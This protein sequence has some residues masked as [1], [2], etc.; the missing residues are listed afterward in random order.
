[1]NT[2]KIRRW[3][4]KTFAIVAM[5]VLILGGLMLTGCPLGEYDIGFEDGFAEDDW[6][7]EGYDDSWEAVEYEILYEGDEIPSPTAPEYDRG[8]WDG[9]WTAYNDGYFVAYDDAFSIGFE[10]GYTAAFFEDYEDF[11][12]SDVHV[13]YG[14]GNYDDGYNDGFSE[15]RVFG[16]YDYKEGLPEDPAD[17]EEDYRSGTDWCVVGVC[18]GEAG[19]VYLYEWG[20]NPALKSAKFRVERSDAPSI[21]H[22]PVE[23]AAKSKRSQD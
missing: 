3:R 10:E 14:T 2:S 12:L 9:V 18:T 22:A 4:Q 5:P 17:A 21:R 11:L 19:P 23:G 7:W 20:T 8:Y 6:Y 13:E 16:A 15:G 1:M